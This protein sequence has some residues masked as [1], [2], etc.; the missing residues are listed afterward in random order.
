[1]PDFK[2]PILIFFGGLLLLAGYMYQVEID[3]SSLIGSESTASTAPILTDRI[4]DSKPNLVFVLADQWRA[5][6]IGYASNTQIITPNLDKLSAQ[7]L[8]FQNAVATMAVCAPWRASFLTGQYPLTHGIFY[9][10]KPLATKAVT[11]GKI[12]KEAGYQTGYIGKWHLNGHA[13]GENSS[14]GR[15]LPVPKERRQGFDYWK[16]R[17]V[18]HDYNNSYYFDEE[19]RKQTWSGYDAFPQTDSAISFISRNKKNPFVLVLSYGPPHDP[20]FSAPKEYQA[21]YV[22][23]KLV[24]RPNVAVEFQD[25]A[26]RVLAGYYAHATA[27][28]HAIGDLLEAIELA[29]IADNTIFVFTSEHGDML[30]SKG[31][32]KKQ[33]PWDEAIKVPMLMR[34]PAKLKPG[35]VEN[36]IGTPDLLPT[37]LGLSGIK[38]PKSVE[39]EDF[40]KDLVPGRDLGNHAALIELIV[41]FHEW[42]FLNG[43]REYRG[44]RTV[45]YTYVKDLKGPWLLYDNQTDPYQMKNLVNDPAHADLQKELEAM[46]QAKLRKTKDEFLP[47]DAYMTQWNYL[48]DP[49]DSLRPKD[50]LMINR[51]F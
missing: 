14:A 18:T 41:P 17:E 4:P 19:N 9:N 47:A 12:Y 3:V 29:G 28:D 6:E 39:G 51:D 22:A 5:Q 16:V 24:L 26:R 8:I 30:M 23:K 33:R 35:I 40:S 37:L 48:Y 32:L 46:L 31:A 34:Y 38:I 20:Y 21:L 49:R 1:M 36:P 43:G 50:Y 11:L 13:R 25:S 7:S 42:K 45:R 2:R 27:L 44:I 15:N 10:D